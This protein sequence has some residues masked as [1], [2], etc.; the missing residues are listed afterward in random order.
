MPRAA[1]ALGSNL[2]DRAGTLARATR[3]LRAEP[4][5]RLLATSPVYETSPVGGPA[6]Q[7]AYLNAAVT[8]ETDRPADELLHFLHAVEHRFGRVRTVPDAPRPL[9]LD[10]L[11]YD[12]LVVQFPH[13]TVPHP[14][15]TERAFVLVPLC[16]I[17]ADWRHP[18]ANLRCARTAR[19]LAGERVG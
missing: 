3:R 2:G 15:L 19:P 13:C 12:E 11:L 4:G 14:R 10:L 16:D 1:I 9:D 5:V 7:G 17:A 18:V 6:G 8:L